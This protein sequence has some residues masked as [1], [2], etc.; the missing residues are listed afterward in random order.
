MASKKVKCDQISGLLSPWLQ[1]RRFYAAREWVLTGRLLDYGCSVADFSEWLPEDV[2]YVGVESDLSIAAAARARHPEL[3]IISGNLEVDTNFLDR[4][5][6]APFDYVVMMA[7]IEHLS[8]P[9]EVL[10]RLYAILV[11]DGQIII[12]TPRPIGK[13]L[14]DIGAVVGITSKVA[15]EEHK[16]LLSRRELSELL[17]HIGFQVKHYK[18]FLFGLNQLIVGVKEI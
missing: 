6:D 2:V 12:T 9:E 17:T 5:L 3:E 4:F 16:D 13:I 11:P 7:V 8:N 18:R 14:L 10:K 15:H 1:R